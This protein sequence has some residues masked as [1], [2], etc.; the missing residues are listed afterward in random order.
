MTASHSDLPQLPLDLPLLALVGLRDPDQ[1]DWARLRAFQ[2]ARIHKLSL[3]RAIAHALSAVITFGVF[4][5]DVPLIG[6][7]LWAAVIVA[8][9]W[10]LV[11]LDHSLADVERRA[12]TRIRCHCV[13]TTPTTH[14]ARPISGKSP[15]NRPKVMTALSAWA[16]AR[17]S[18]SL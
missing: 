14:A 6:L 16:M 7:A 4:F 9:Q 17:L 5:G 18:E 10:H 13:T 2:Y 12:M 3:S 1:G 8:T 15:K 11:R